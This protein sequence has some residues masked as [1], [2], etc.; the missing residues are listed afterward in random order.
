MMLSS[1]P[2]ETTESRSRTDHLSP[3]EGKGLQ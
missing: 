1:K 3:G 2:A